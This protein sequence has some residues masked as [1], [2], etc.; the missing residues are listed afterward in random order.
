MAEMKERSLP[1]SPCSRCASGTTTEE[2]ISVSNNIATEERI[3]ELKREEDEEREDNI[4]FVF[5][6]FVLVAIIIIIIASSFVRARAG[7]M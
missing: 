5:G 7:K 4:C 1:N 2:S 6:V 3:A